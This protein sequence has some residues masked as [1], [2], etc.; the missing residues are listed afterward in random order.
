MKKLVI[1]SS[2]FEGEIVLTYTADGNLKAFENNATL[3]PLQ[4][5]WLIKE[6]PWRKEQ[7]NIMLGKSKT[8]KVVETDVVPTFHEFYLAY[9]NKVG[10]KDAESTWNK[11]PAHKKVMAFAFIK[12][13]LDRK[14]KEG[15]ALPYPQT[16]L[17]AEPW[18]D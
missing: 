15:T 11:L 18:N 5:A 2:L 9:N 10:K 6:M 3:T 12:K 13:Y 14:K 8:M 7:L 4:Q 1:T 16:Y 17:N